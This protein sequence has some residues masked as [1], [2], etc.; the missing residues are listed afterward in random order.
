[1]V[2][3]RQHSV[4]ILNFKEVWLQELRDAGQWHLK[5]TFLLVGLGAY[6][7]GLFF[8]YIVFEFWLEVD[9]LEVHNSW[10]KNKLLN[11]DFEIYHIFVL[12]LLKF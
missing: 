8:C 1:M 3:K 10:V 11:A 12:E 4:F 6:T 5:E 7:V 2:D 9:G